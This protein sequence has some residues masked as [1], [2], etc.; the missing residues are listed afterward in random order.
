MIDSTIKNLTDRAFSVTSDQFESLALDVFRFQAKHNAIYNQYIN[1]LGC[2]IQNVGSLQQIPFLPIDFFKNN[3]IIIGDIPSQ[4]V[5]S[6]SGTTGPNTSKHYIADLL[7]YE[8]SFTEGFKAFYG[9]PEKYCIIALLPSYLERT[10]SSLIYMMDK[11]ITLS[12]HPQ[13]GFYLNYEGKMLS[14]I[15]NLIQQNQPI[16][17]IGVTYALLDF[18]E[19][20]PINLGN[21]IV[22]ETGGMKG[23][24]K[25]MVREDLHQYLQS[26]LGVSAIHSEYGMTELLSQAYS[27]GNGIFTCPPWMKVLIRDIYDPFTFLN[28]N[29]SGAINVFSKPLFMFVYRNQRSWKNTLQQFI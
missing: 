21:T 3:K 2:K 29:Q 14:T 8:R 26:K 24:R 11:L 16:W 13:S 22:L 1:Y 7:L 15:E 28:S 18:A 17:L 10:G 4:I 20:H 12:N 25:E 27:T 5:F 6:S 23:Y 19:N 9:N